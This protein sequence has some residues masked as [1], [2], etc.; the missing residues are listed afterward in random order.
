MTKPAPSAAY[1]RGPIGSPSESA[2]MIGPPLRDASDDIRASWTAVV[3]RAIEAL[4]NSGWITGLVDT[5]VGQMIGAGMAINYQPDGSV[6]GWDAATT[7]QWA[8]RVERRFQDWAET[9][10]ECDAGARQ[11]L[12]QMQ[13]AA[14]RHWFATGEHF[15]QFVTMRR[16]GTLHRTKLRQI[17]AWWVPTT[18]RP[19]SGIDHG[20]ALDRHGASVGYLVNYRD[21]YTNQRSE[22]ML[23]ARDPLGRPVML[24]VFDAQ[25]SAL[26]GISV[27][28]PILRTLRNYDQLMSA[29]ITAKMIHAIFA[30]T[31]ESDYPTSDVFDALR[32]TDEASPP[33]TD[34]SPFSNY[35]A[36]KIGWAKSVKIDLGQHGKI[37]HLM[38][39]E[40]L[41]LHT[42][43]TPSDNFEPLANFL[44]RETARC[45][46]A[47]FA[48]VSGDHRGESYA[49]MKLSTSKSWPLI[50]YR[51]RH[52][53][54][55]FAQAAFAAW[56][57]DDIDA[58]GTPIPGGLD[59]F[60]ANR[61]ALSR[62]VW[63]GPAKPIADETKAAA[64]HKT[65]R[66]MGVMSDQMI[67]AD[68]GVD[69]QDVYDQRAE[70]QA[71]RQ[72]L[73]IHGGITNGGT[74]IDLLAAD[75]EQQEEEAEQ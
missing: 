21:R 47:A 73:G 20:V 10:A 13:G 68:L 14:V 71:D 27:F 74:D 53:A 6:F 62:A 46:G 25:I 30:A 70:E 32:T 40:T 22:I 15:T 44:L 18:S 8:R 7:S 72:R 64:A 4:Q 5:M 9:P 75:E 57:E 1:L 23:P 63:R 48:D 28:A 29:S 65:Y 11:T 60:L 56:L 38:S 45:A 66:E 54:A 36:E 34:S 41:K 43:S 42:A 69:Y 49:S 16:P 35:M 51:R 61:A 67:C 37:P 39:G 12:A 50:L 2:L 55:P 33:T 58:G 59:A 52:I 17:P 19:F 31:I 3:A 24:H 26:R